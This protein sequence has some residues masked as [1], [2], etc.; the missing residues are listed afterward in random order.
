MAPPTGSAAAGPRAGRAAAVAVTLAVAL[1]P[2]AGYAGW[3]TVTPG[4][5]AVLTPAVGVWRADGVH[6]ELRG[7]CAALRPGDTVVAVAPGGYTVR[8]DGT[9]RA[10]AEP[11]VPGRWGEALAAGWSALLFV[12]SLAVL[13]GYALV[14]GRGRDPAAAA[15]AVLAA[16]L[17]GSTVV[18]VLGLPA[19]ALGTGGQWLFLFAVQVVYTVAWSGLVAFTLLFPAPSRPRRGTL[20]AVYAVPLAVL[21]AA[22]ALLPGPVGSP[23]WV[24]GM[25]VVQSAL[26]VAALATGL[27]IGTR[28]FRRADRD[29]VAGRQLRWI[30]AGGWTASALVLAG[31]FVPAL[32]TGAPLLPASWLGLP[33][34]ALVVALAVAL[35]RLTL[36]DL[37]VVLRRT[38]VYAALTVAVVALYLVVVTVS[39]AGLPGSATGPVAV[40]GA[41]AVAL[42][43]NPLRLLL[44]RAVGRA[45]YGDRDDP[46]TA[47]RRLGGHLAATPANVLPVAAADV[48]AALRVPFARIEV[49]RGGGDPVHV[50]VAGTEPAGVALWSEPLRHGGEV[51]GALVVAPREVGERPGPADRALLAD[52]AGR[53]APAARVLALDMDLQRSRERLVLAREEERRALRRALHDEIGPS[54]AAL[55]LRAETARRLLR[56]GAPD[57]DSELDRL[58]REATDAAGVLR[59]L[60]YDLRPPALDEL[61]LAGAIREQARRLEPLEVDVGIDPADGLPAAVEV[62]AYRIVVE[63]MTNAARHGGRRCRVHVAREGDALDVRVDDDGPG[64]TDG[65]RAGVGITSIRERAGELGGRCTLDA[66]PGGGARVAVTVP[67]RGPS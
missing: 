2:A 64:F 8:R 53:L 16:G 28:R 61:G 45:F 47:L 40:A 48:V 60:A 20:A 62:A 39:A 54:V 37:D 44:H 24:G 35:L 55:G 7:R 29:G 50:A 46:A 21:A 31:W 32:I 5:C 51:V 30:G 11:A 18:T 17:L 59:R 36:F 6:P 19:A 57:V 4:D 49:L 38:M 43:V 22:A 10:V 66:A 26:T 52:L 56:A 23:G 3:W 63:A 33:G 13:A 12:L 15:L 41:V 1:V 27:A 9:L 42:L 34:L 25:I 67:L 65:F 14:R 58:R